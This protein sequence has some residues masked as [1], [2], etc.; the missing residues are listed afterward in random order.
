MKRTPEKNNLIMNTYQNV[1]RKM[2]RISQ[3]RVGEIQK[4]VGEIQESLTSLAASE[5][6]MTYNSQ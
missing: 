6:A 5:S 1:K 4:R 2:K 3:I